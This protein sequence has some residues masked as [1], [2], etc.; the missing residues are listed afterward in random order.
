MSD[1]GF[2][3]G[4]MDGTMFQV[5]TAPAILGAKPKMPNNRACFMGSLGA[6]RAV[7]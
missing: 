4:P 3:W 1:T 6:K 7:T 2:Q 5:A